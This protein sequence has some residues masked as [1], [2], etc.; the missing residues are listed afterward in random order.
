MEFD[1]KKDQL[2]LVEQISSSHH[3]VSMNTRHYHDSYEIYYYLGGNMTY[4]INDRSYEVKSRNIVFINE[5]TYHRSHYRGPYADDRVLIMFHP[6]MLGLFANK[7]EITRA[8]QILSKTPVM[9]FKDNI[10]E[11]IHN[12][13]MLIVWHYNK[14]NTSML[15]IMTMISGLILCLKD[16][17][18]LGCLNEHEPPLAVSDIKISDVA[19]YI[20]ENFQSKISLDDLSSRFFINK[21][22][23]CHKFKKLTGQT[24]VEFI[25]EKRLVEA[26]RLLISSGH[27]VLD[28]SQAVGFES[29]N[30][31]NTLFKRKFGLTP[32]SYKAKILNTH[33]KN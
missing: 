21:Y 24:I 32:L 9:D 16:Y 27:T 20:S 19:R 4:F 5:N 30:H 7:G 6:S 8:L 14:K 22:Y 33:K 12:L 17:V 1:Y 18:E 10:K 15:H 23:L 13:V 31:F 26:R 25:N 11:Q 29:V 28:I 2:V 3:Q